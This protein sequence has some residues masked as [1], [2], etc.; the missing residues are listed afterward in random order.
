MSKSPIPLDEAAILALCERIEKM[1]AAETPDVTIPAVT[2]LMARVMVGR[3][4]E[5]A[6]DLIFRAYELGKRS[7]EQRA[8]Q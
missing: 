8:L 3:P 5:D 7:G 2:L 4:K 6:L 1:L